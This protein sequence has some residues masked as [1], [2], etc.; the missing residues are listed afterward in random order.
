MKI[1][2]MTNCLSGIFMASFTVPAFAHTGAGAA[3]SFMD[4]FIHPWLGID[5]MLV[6]FTIGLWGC[7]QGGKQIWLL[8][9]TFLFWIMAGAALGF[10]NI[11]LPYPELWVALSV[12]AC[13]LLV[14]NNLKINSVL[15]MVLAALFAISHGY[16]HATEIAE[17]ANQANYVSGFLVATTILHCLGITAGLFGVKAFKT[18]RVCFGLLFTAVGMLLLAG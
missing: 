2:N 14:G 13:G 16:V 7:L 18:L 15:A 9:M 3:H 12:V 4:G 5:H 11:N 8:P 10:T 17:N 6:M 1:Q